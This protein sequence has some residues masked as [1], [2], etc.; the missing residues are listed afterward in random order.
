MK[1]TKDKNGKLSIDGE[2]KALIT[3]ERGEEW[4]KLEGLTEKDFKSICNFVI[5]Y[6]EK[7]KRLI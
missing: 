7:K 1:I 5:I 2:H 3:P 6:P 4:M